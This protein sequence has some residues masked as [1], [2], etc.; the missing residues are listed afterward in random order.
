MARTAKVRQAAAL[1]VRGDNQ[2]GRRITSL[3]EL[4]R[5]TG[6]SQDYLRAVKAEDDWEGQALRYAQ[7]CRL[8]PTLEAGDLIEELTKDREVL[9]RKAR[10][11][12]EKVDLMSPDDPKFEEAF[13][14]WSKVNQ[15]WERVAGIDC[16][17][18]ANRVRQV[19]AA[20]LQARAD[21]EERKRENELAEN[22]SGKIVPV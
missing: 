10:E 12:R 5:V 16:L 20:K 4:A 19:E 11:L 21:I 8:V 17:L 13:G 18:E 6:S 9:G 2:T 1:F 3:A 15:R 7:E 14:L 22:V